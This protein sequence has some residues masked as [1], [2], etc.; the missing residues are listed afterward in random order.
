M[1]DPFKPGGDIPMIVPLRASG[2]VYIDNPN[3]FTKFLPWTTSRKCGDSRYLETRMNALKYGYGKNMDVKKLVNDVY[4][5]E[6]LPD[7][8]KWECV[9]CP[10]G[11]SCKGDIFWEGIINF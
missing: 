2:S 7:P 10:Y 4:G 11:G 6:F 8:Y 3:P 9:E 5:E 1:P